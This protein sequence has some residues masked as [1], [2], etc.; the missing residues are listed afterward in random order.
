[1]AAL[2]GWGWKATQAKHTA[3]PQPKPAEPL[4]ELCVSPGSRASLLLAQPSFI[5]NPAPLTE[6]AIATA[7]SEKIIGPDLAL[8]E[9][10]VFNETRVPDMPRVRTAA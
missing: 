5:A 4:C 7:L 3:L 2:G 1:M 10:R 8:E 9:V 6:A